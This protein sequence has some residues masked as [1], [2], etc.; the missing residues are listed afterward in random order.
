MH[1][2]VT[3]L[4]AITISV[5]VVLNSSARPLPEDSSCCS[6]AA[7]ALEA[8]AKVRPGM[9]RADVERHVARDGGGQFPSPTRYVYPKCNYLKIDVAFDDDP[10]ND[11]ALSASD[12]VASV[13]RPYVEYPMLD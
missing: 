2:R 4:L 5:V 8:F 9:T 11:E 12:R 6:V 13:S 1:T 7:E 3:I 10:E